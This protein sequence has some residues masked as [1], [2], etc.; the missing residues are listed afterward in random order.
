MIKDNYIVAHECLLRDDMSMG[1]VSKAFS[2]FFNV[3]YVSHLPVERGT[4]KTFD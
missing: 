4:G 3:F 1:K 2:Y